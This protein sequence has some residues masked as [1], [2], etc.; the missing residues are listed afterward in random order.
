MRSSATT[1]SPT[2]LNTG[3]LI[4][5]F[6]PNLNGQ[7]KDLTLTPDGTKLIAV[8]MFTQA[9][10]SARGRI[11]V[12]DIP[13]GQN[14]QGATLSTAVVPAINGG[15]QSVAATNSTIY[16]GGYFSSIN[17]GLRVRIGAVGRDQRSGPTVPSLGRG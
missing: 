16:V 1:C 3:Q 10:S 7:V 8:G 6:D 5:A 2:T 15:T 9:G 4:T 12:W 14:G 17:G 13:S 11:A